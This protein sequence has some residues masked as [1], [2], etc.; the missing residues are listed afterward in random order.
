[1]KK[2]IFSFLLFLLAYSCIEFSSFLGLSLLKK[3]RN[4]KFNPILT[5]SLSKN[6]Q[7]ILQDFIAGKTTF[8]IHSPVLGWAIKPN[9]F[10]YGLYRANSKGIRANKEYQFFPDDSIIRIAA[11]GDSF[12]HCENVKNEDTWEEQLSSLKTQLEVI[13]FGV[14]GYGLDQAFLR[15]QNE[16]RLY[17]PHI[18]LIGF[19]EENINRLV[20][21][22]RPFY[23]PGIPLTKP[24]FIV[25][26]NQLSLLTNPLK[27]VRDCNILLNNPKSLL[28]KFGENDFH[29]KAGIKDGVFDFSPSV[30][31]LKIL[32][33]VIFKYYLEYSNKSIYKK[34]YFNTKGEAFSICTKLFDEFYD[35]AQR[36][37]S[38]PI[39]VLFANETDIDRY[40]KTKTKVYEPLIQYISAKGYRYIDLVEAFEKYGQSLSSKE[41]FIEHHYSLL[42]NSIVAQFIFDY[43][44][45]NSFAEVNA[46]RNTPR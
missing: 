45:K 37:N 33:H 28:S 22:F 19:M 39:I 43:L 35:E 1:M 13:N 10:R 20:N 21:V 5:A 42:G 14:G 2:Y 25:Q 24:R 23:F 32:Y 44:N 41:F 29:F 46:F 15:Y 30:R 7:L 4:I 26:K 12:T 40:R 31:V 9:A 6:N 17:H 36:N 38:L 3:F 27:D 11:F 34:G 16:G 8:G 18:V